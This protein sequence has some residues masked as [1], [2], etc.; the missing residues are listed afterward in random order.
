MSLHVSSTQLELTLYMAKM[1]GVPAQLTREKI[2]TPSIVAAWTARNT[3]EK[4][5]IKRN[6]DTVNLKSTG[7]GTVP[8]EWC[9]ASWTT[10]LSN[11][12]TCP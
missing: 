10:H 8:M 1:S 4:S 6:I 11:S 9:L 7:G 2:S 5:G 12:T 3:T